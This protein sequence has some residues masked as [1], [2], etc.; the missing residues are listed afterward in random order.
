M[1]CRP[2]TPRHP[3]NWKRRREFVASGFASAAVALAAAATSGPAR[4]HA[5]SFPSRPIRI[6]VP[7]GA[8][9]IADLCARAVGQAIAEQ[10]GAQVIVEN[11]PGAGGVVATGQVAKA[12]PDGHT[13]LLMSNATAVSTAL[14]RSLPYDPL[15]DFAPVSTLGS[16]G[17]A[18][19]VAPGSRFP[20]LA[21]LMGFARAQPGRLTVGTIAI[22]STQNLAAELLRASAGVDFQIV[23]FNGTPALLTA[24]LGGHVDAAFEIVG[25]TIAQTGARAPRVL[26]VTSERRSPLMPAVPTVGETVL[27]G[28]RVSSWN[29][30]AVPAGTPAPV[31]AR[32]NQ[33]VLRALAL[34]AVSARLR[35]LGV[36]ARGSTPEELGSLLAGET[37]RWREVIERAGI[38]KQ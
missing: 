38:E 36:E 32:L 18:I 21:A 4:V 19:L 29:A 6:V 23:P 10:L 13:L 17:L 37:R 25:P 14:F 22:G 9:G 2:A 5:A 8:G 34:P 12:Q 30:L 31:I 20:D 26:A 33:A 15:R 11:K 27:P 24:V 3:V 1:R 7:F 16:F 35:A 28:Y